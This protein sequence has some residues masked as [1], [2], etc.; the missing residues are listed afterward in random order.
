MTEIV[1]PISKYANETT[2]LTTRIVYTLGVCHKTD[3]YIYQ[4]NVCNL[5]T[6][7]ISS[8]DG[9]LRQLCLHVNNKH[10]YSVTSS[11]KVHDG[12][13]HHFI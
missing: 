12:E 8:L 3:K 5:V 9:A 6:V 13:K 7:R 1:V 2:T 4:E 11:Q 10:K